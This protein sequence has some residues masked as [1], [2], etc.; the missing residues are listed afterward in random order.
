MEAVNG[1][2]CDSCNKL[3]CKYKCLICYDYDLCADCHRKS[4]KVHEANNHVWNHPMQLIKA[5]IDYS[6]CDSCQTTDFRGNRYKCM[7]CRDYDLCS[8]C[9]RYRA[10]T[11]HNS[12]HPMERIDKD[13][14]KGIFCDLC[15]KRNYLGNQFK[16]LVCHNF[17]LCYDCHREVKT[18]H[19]TNNH[20]LDHPMQLLKDGSNIKSSGV[21]IASFCNSCRVDDFRGCRYKC[22]ICRDFDLC[23]DCLQGSVVI[24]HTFSH[25]MEYTPTVLNYC[26]NA[27]IN[28]T[29]TNNNIT[30][31]TLNIQEN[32]SEE[33]LNSFHKVGQV[34]MASA[35]CMNV[36]GQIYPNNSSDTIAEE[37][38]CKTASCEFIGNNDFHG[39]CYGCFTIL[40]KQDSSEKRTV[41]AS[42]QDLLK[43]QAALATKHEML[44]R[45][46]TLTSKKMNKDDKVS[47]KENTY[48]AD[49]PSVQN[50]NDQEKHICLVCLE[51]PYNTVLLP[52]GHVWLCYEC[53]STLMYTT[54]SCPA[55]RS[56]VTSFHRVY[57]GS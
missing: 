51:R 47:S 30:L 50:Q 1:I 35:V 5:G 42:K 45:Q 17:N 49:K 8:D 18:T 11:E 16:C 34:N 19:Q 12:S 26:K 6:L 21:F 54:K 57:M 7:V 20:T 23:L 31:D 53:A 36:R 40:I 38:G 15:N 44:K 10:S 48:M 25:P 28:V 24:Q 39:Y 32:L 2:S 46:S 43:K 4:K 13:L 41:L 14:S 56:N 3:G 9:H 29:P 33:I 52:C 37:A 27:G 22:M 55:C